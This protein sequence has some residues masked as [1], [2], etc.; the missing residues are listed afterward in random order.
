MEVDIGQMFAF[1]KMGEWDKVDD[2]LLKIDDKLWLLTEQIDNMDDFKTFI[3]D[4]FGIE[5]YDE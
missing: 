5:L 4:E 3:L 1:A 2:M